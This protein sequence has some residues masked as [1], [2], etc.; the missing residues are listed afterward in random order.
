MM[1]DEQVGL[2][3]YIYMFPF[4]PTLCPIQP[5]HVEQS[6]PELGKIYALIH[7]LSSSISWIES[8]RVLRPPQSTL[9]DEEA[10]LDAE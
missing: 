5:H 6:S 4:S 7:N 8:E 10:G 3:Q 1:A 9:A 2:S